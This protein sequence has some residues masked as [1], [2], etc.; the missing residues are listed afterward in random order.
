MSSAS[1]SSGRCRRRVVLLRQPSREEDY[2]PPRRYCNHR[3]VASRWMAWTDGNPGQRFYGCPLYNQDGTCGF[4]AW[5]D[6]EFGKRAK[7]M[8]KELLD[9]I[10]K[11]YD[12]NCSLRIASHGHRV[13]EE[14]DS[15]HGELRELKRRNEL[16]DREVRKGKNKFKL[17]M[18]LLLFTFVWLCV[19]YVKM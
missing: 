2:E 10:D 12:E 9:D 18:T 6:N 17:A 11:L 5:H 4:F 13:G 15:I 14:L 16:Y 3:M 8:I 1:S 19:L 7:T